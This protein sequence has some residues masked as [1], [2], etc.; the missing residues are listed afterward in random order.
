M[1][2]CVEGSTQDGS[3]LTEGENRDIKGGRVPCVTGTGETSHRGAVVSCAYQNA[4]L[5]LP[6]DKGLNYRA[7]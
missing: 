2:E 1:Y 5:E 6:L 7:P 3:A 4:T